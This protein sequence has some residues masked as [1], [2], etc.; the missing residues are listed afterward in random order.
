MIPSVFD[1][2]YSLGVSILFFFSSRR[3]H[4][5][6]ALVTGVQT[7]ALPI[8]S[9]SLMWQYTSC[10]STGGMESSDVELPSMPLYHCA[11]LDNFLSTDIYLCATSLILRRP[12]PSVFLDTIPLAMITNLFLPPTF[13]F[14]LLSPPPFS[15]PS[16]SP[17]FFFY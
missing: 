2:I 5:R 8:C 10:I 9:R 16:L 1:F 15:P 12:D 14:P 3:R 7:C 17:F 6:C 13:L 4:T 11:Q